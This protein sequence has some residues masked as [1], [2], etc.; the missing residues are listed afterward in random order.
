MRKTDS[1]A[2]CQAQGI[3]LWGG[4]QGAEPHFS[5]DSGACSSLRSMVLNSHS[6]SAFLNH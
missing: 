6:L 4:A 1:L 5:A 2:P 3:K